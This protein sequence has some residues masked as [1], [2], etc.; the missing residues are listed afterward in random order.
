[1]MNDLKMLKNLLSKSLPFIV[2]GI[3]FG[4]SSAIAATPS[5]ASVQGRV[6]L[7]RKTAAAEG[8]REI[9]KAPVPLKFG[10]QLK[11]GSGAIAKISCPGESKPKQIQRAGERLGIG[12]LC[13]Q[14]KAVIGKGAPPI[15]SMSGPN[16]K[17]PYL[18]SPHRTLI[19]NATPTLRWNT[20]VGAT[21]YTVQVKNGPRIIW[22]TQ[23]KETQVTYP[24]KPI[25]Q[26]GV[27]YSVTIQ[28]D[29]GKLAQSETGNQFIILKDADAKVV[30]TEIKLINQSDF[31]PEV[32][33]LNLAEYYTDYEVPEPVAYGLT[34][35]TSKSYRL[36]AD[37]IAVLESFLKEN[38][39]SSPLFYRMLGDFYAQTGVMRPAEQAY[40]Q[41]IEQVR[42]SEDVEEWSLAMYG[43]GELY[44][45]IQDSQQAIIWYSQARIGFIVLDDQRKIVAE[46]S[47]ERLKKLTNPA[48][49]KAQS[50]NKN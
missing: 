20:V 32:K 45:A 3:V 43:L 7:K 15:E 1:M 10:D 38:Q 40:L 49:A 47:I 4:Q 29:T 23:V 17:I 50:G 34:D 37:A 36:T 5:V 41:A 27:P 2:I 30:Q 44:E 8:F 6:E 18:I 35:K 33:A 13:P 19:L 48:P 25:L 24:G 16:P 22:Q 31:S 46:R 14:W 39:S 42:S 28:T 26:P 9:K 11:L 12:D 21:Q